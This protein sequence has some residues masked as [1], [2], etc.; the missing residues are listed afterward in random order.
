MPLTLAGVSCANPP[1]LGIGKRDQKKSMAKLPAPSR[2]AVA[3]FMR[4]W[5]ELEP[6]RAS[7]ITALSER[8]FHFDPAPAD[9]ASWLCRAMIGMLGIS[10]IVIPTSCL[11]RADVI[12]AFPRLA[13]AGLLWSHC[14]ACGYRLGRPD[15]APPACPVCEADATS[16]DLVPDVAGRQVFMNNAD[17]AVRICG[18]EKP[19]QAAAD[20]L[21]LTLLGSKPPERLR[22]SGGVKVVLNEDGPPLNAINTLQA[23]T[24]IPDLAGRLADSLPEQDIVVGRQSQE[25]RL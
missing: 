18:R 19:Y 15:A 4:R 13:E 2:D 10:C 20:G 21:T 7:A 9:L 6:K 17:L 14:P 1:S 11:P 12:G 16:P 3:G 24:V 23:L 22:V 25:H 8:A 5:N